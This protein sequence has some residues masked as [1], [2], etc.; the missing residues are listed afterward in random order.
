MDFS[1]NQIFE[2]PVSLKGCIRLQKLNVAQNIIEYC[3]VIM[4]TKSLEFV[5][6]SS[7]RIA[8][9]PEAQIGEYI[10]RYIFVRTF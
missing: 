9:F 6:F 5:D 1:R 2:L 3:D 10:W 8:N 4:D 7:N